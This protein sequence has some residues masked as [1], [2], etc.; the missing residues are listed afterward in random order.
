MPYRDRKGS[1]VEDATQLKEEAEAE[2]IGGAG[3]QALQIRESGTIKKRHEDGANYREPAPCSCSWEYEFSVNI[4]PLARDV[5]K[6]ECTLNPRVVPFQIFLHKDHLSLKS[7]EQ[8]EIEMEKDRKVTKTIVIYNTVGTRGL[9]CVSTS[10]SAGMPYRDRK[11][12]DVEDAT[13]LKEE[14]EAEHIGGA[15][16]QALQ[17]RESGTIKKRHEDGANYREPAP[18][19]CSWEVTVMQQSCGKSRNPPLIFQL[20]LLL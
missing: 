5:L 19:S 14:A 17:I 15:G 4:P 12:S 16:R 7:M 13:Q 9:L 2:H 1:D 3:R 11:G 18:C 8:N 6:K 10:K 20:P